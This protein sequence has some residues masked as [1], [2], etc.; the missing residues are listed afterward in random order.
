MT[1]V[2]RSMVKA[3]FMFFVL[4]VSGLVLAQADASKS[5]GQT[6]GWLP[7]DTETLV[8]VQAPS[9]SM[10]GKDVKVLSIMSWPAGFSEGKLKG[11]A[12]LPASSVVFGARKFQY[13]DTIGVGGFEGAWIA[14][15]TN[16]SLASAKSILSKTILNHSTIAGQLVLSCAEATN[17]HEMRH[18]YVVIIDYA[19]IV[20]TDKL[21]IE[22]L[23]RRMSSTP[24]NRAIPDM[25]EEWKYVD[26]SA[27]FW[28]IRHI[29]PATQL[30]S[31][32]L[33]MHD[34]S[35]RGF[36]VSIS[37]DGT[38]RV[39]SISD[40]P[41]GFD[42]AKAIWGGDELKPVVTAL[43]KTATEIVIDKDPNQ[44]ERGL[45]YLAIAMGFAIAI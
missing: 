41:H 43:T 19:L 26:K 42:I 22:S 30:K 9:N 20:A 25:L 8:V 16:S 17:A 1:S 29:N 45:F 7:T 5:I 36:G 13:P 3:A 15:L 31:W 11:L 33:D 32:G 18:F 35:L 21:Y 12:S 14:S 23:L 40:H 34:K 2:E 10:D 44:I 4:L 27:A 6:I 39:V 28:G 24:T 38:L 37:K